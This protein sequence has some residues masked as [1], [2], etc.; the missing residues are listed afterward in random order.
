VDSIGFSS[1]SAFS[2]L[3]IGVTPMCSLA[4]GRWDN[5]VRTQGNR[6]A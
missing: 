3:D 6:K 2:E 1:E 4:D 5:V